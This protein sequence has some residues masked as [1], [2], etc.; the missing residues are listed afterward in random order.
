[1]HESQAR[2]HYAP[3]S[4]GA[5]IDTGLLRRAIRD[6]E[7]G[8]PDDEVVPA[9]RRPWRIALRALVELCLRRRKPG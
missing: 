8:Q 1:M 6:A 7:G 4:V 9:A 5:L 3:V 2:I